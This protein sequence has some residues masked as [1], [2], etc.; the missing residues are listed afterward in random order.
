MEHIVVF[1]Q[2]EV[3]V[4]LHPVDAPLEKEQ[5][6]ALPMLLP[7]NPEIVSDNDIGVVNQHAEMLVEEGSRDSPDH[8]GPAFE[9]PAAL[10]HWSTH[11]YAFG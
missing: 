4:P 9:Q 10:P 1:P 3:S 11:C 5:R 8:L 2:C 7:E 6:P